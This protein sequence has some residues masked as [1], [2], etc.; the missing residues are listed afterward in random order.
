MKQIR[1]LLAI[2]LVASFGACSKDT[3]APGDGTN[4]P[5]PVTPTTESDV[6]LAGARTAWTFVENNT[7]ASTGL[8]QAHDNFQFITTWDI[9]SQIAATYSAHELGIIDDANY[10]GR[11]RKILATLT[12]LPLFQGAA[13]NRFYD[14]KTGQMVDRNFNISSTGFGWSTTDLGRLLIWLRVLAV[15]QPQY[16]AQAT[17]IKNRLNMSRLVSRGTV[18]GVDVDANGNTVYYAETGL[19]YEQ[20]AAGGVALWGQRASNSL[21]PTAT[22]QATTV[23]GVR[24]WIDGRGNARL[25]SEPYI[26]MGLE[27]G[28]LASALRDQAQAVLAAQQAR[29]DQQGI[30]TIVTEHAMPDA[31]YYF[32]YYSVYHSGKTFVVEGPGYGTVVSNPRWVSSKAAFAW[33][34]L[35]QTDYT[36]RAFN[37]VQVAAIPGDGWGAGVYEG[38]LQPTGYATLNTAGMILESALYQKRGQPVLSQPIN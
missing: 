19:G 30:I 14:S 13:F 6:F 23:L 5:P 38:S 20:Y 25:T 9:A 34:A 22:G 37:A 8:A 26:M 4:P 33:R 32:Y 15:H 1:N 35:F 31:P 3:T 24:V 27:T 11:I 10:D 21:N 28:F 16:S 12:T 29:Y 2:A 36:L 17:A 18:P 7:Q